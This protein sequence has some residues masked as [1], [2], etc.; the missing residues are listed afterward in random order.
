MKKAR[1]TMDEKLIAEAEAVGINASMYYFLP[2]NRREV[3][4]RK[5]IERAKKMAAEQSTPADE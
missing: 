1:K 2:A 4:L 5:D 3:L